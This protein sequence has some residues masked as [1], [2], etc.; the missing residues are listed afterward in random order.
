MLISLLRFCRGCF[1]QEGALPFWLGKWYASSSL[2]RPHLVLFLC[3]EMPSNLEGC[4][5]WY[6]YCLVPPAFASW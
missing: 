3:E 2:L 5:K 6:L 4:P 1:D